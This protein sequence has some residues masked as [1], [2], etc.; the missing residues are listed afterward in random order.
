MNYSHENSEGEGKST[1]REA[2]AKEIRNS[3]DRNCTSFVGKRVRSVVFSLWI[4]ISLQ[5]RLTYWNESG[6]GS[7]AG[8][9]HSR[10]VI[11]Q[12][13]AQWDCSRLKSFSIKGEKKK[14]SEVNKTSYSNAMTNG[15]GV[16]CL[17]YFDMYSPSKHHCRQS[18]SQ[19][20][21]QQ[22]RWA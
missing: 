9:G 20:L 15:N 21:R 18:T 12:M 13:G 19:Q 11:L 8:T 7:K 16:V 17:S 4:I 5:L 10:M 3:R 6:T 2:Q 14:R 22:Q 1:G